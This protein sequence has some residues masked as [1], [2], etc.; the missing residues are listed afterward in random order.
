MIRRLAAVF[1]A[2][3]IPLAVVISGTQAHAS[4]ATPGARML[5]WAKANAAGHWY[6]YG[7][8][9]LAVYDC[10]GLVYRS[11]LE[12]GISLP[13]TTYG[14]L[15]SG[16]RL[17]RT[18]RPVAGDLAFFGTGHVEIVDRGHDVTFGARD[19][20][21]RVGDHPWA[22]SWFRPTMYFHLV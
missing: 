12:T 8:A 10:S 6:S 3:F 2:L 11:A 5:A 7:G 20:G 16:G 14:M 17:V 15:S 21:T 1:A 18:Y 19:W 9:G 13:R 22:G 4:T